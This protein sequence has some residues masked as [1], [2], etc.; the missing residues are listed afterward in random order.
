MSGKEKEL[1]RIAAARLTTANR[2]PITL[3]PTPPP[4]IPYFSPR[5]ILPLSSNSKNAAKKHPS[6]PMQN[7]SAPITSDARPGVSMRSQAGSKR[8]SS[9][10]DSPE[11]SQ[12]EQSKRRPTISKDSR[13]P[14]AEKS[15]NIQSKG[16][17]GVPD[18]KNPSPNAST[19]AKSLAQEISDQL[20][21]EKNSH[22]NNEM[23]A[24][25]ADQ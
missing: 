4:D 24:E 20:L 9:E 18:P 11:N 14:L 12:R 19:P 13:P 6:K 8:Q 23:T 1:D 25:L 3:S 21:R 2:H 22:I 15:N 16:V 17:V 7:P 10:M 5:T